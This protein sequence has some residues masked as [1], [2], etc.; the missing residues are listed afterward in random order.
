MIRTDS[1]EGTVSGGLRATSF[2]STLQK[3]LLSSF[4]DEVRDT[5]RS[6]LE[7]YFQLPLVWSHLLVAL[8]SI[9]VF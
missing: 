7:D 4:D 5:S 6:D 2:I 9:G 3:Q 1:L 8:K